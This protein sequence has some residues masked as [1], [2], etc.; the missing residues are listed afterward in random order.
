MMSQ[1][2]LYFKFFF[3]STL[4]GNLNSLSGTIYE[5]FLRGP[6]ERKGIRNDG[7]VLKLLVVVLGICSTLLVYV[8]ENLGGILSLAIGFGSMAH[9]PLLGMFLLGLYFPRANSRVS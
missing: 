2:V 7:L 6:L 9:G 8:V 3:Y 5:D 1:F 4:S